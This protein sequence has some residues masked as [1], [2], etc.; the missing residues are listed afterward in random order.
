M[1][2]LFL[3]DSSSSVSPAEF[4]SSLEFIVRII[5]QYDIGTTG[6]QVGIVAFSSVASAEAPFAIRIGSIVQK[7]LLIQTVLSLQ[8]L[9]Q[10]GRRTDLALNLAREHLTSF[11]NDAPNIVI[12]LTTGISDNSQ[13][14]LQAAERLQVVS[15]TEVLIVGASDGSDADSNFLDEIFAIGSDPDTDHVFRLNSFQRQSFN[16]IFQPVIEEFCDGKCYACTYNYLSL[17]YIVI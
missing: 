12:L 2:L 3:L 7:E 9:D 5:R 1:D 8:Q 14:T 16:T 17:Y 11:R 6:T 15:D 10:S 4:Q 13:L